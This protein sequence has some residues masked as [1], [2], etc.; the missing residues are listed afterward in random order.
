MKMMRQ[1]LP[2][3]CLYAHNLG[4]GELHKDEG[5]KGK[6]M[7]QYFS[8]SCEPRLHYNRNSAWP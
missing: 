8:D 5:R 3:S 1:F 7:Q 6:I 4:R 2:S